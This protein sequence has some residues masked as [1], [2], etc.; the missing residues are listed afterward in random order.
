[1]QPSS[2]TFEVADGIATLTLNEAERM[3]P[4]D[5]PLIQGCLDAAQRVHEDRSVR[6]LL[7]NARGRAFSVGADLS[8]LKS[9][10][11]RPGGESLGHYVGRLMAERGNPL[12]AALRALPVPVVCAV[13]GAAAGGGVGL[14]LAADIVVAARSAYFYL[15]FVPALGLVPD[16]GSSW[17]LP[18]A[19]GH[20]R[21]LGLTLL[22]DKL[23]AQ[24]AADWGLIWACVDD[25][26]LQDE[27]RLVARRL[28]ALPAHA[29]V[30]TRALFEASRK[31]D[32]EQQLAL[33][34]ERQQALIDGGAFAEGV[35][36]FGERRSPVFPGRG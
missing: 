19:V 7:L 31:N 16:M 36:A 11:Q 18:R 17:F 34:R 26:K 28:A 4:L 10:A 14:A 35:R 20:A 23:P 29:I 21:A 5:A 2:V 22:G 9:N 6:A 24:Q 27:G 30:E 12:M 13:Q 15:P 1:M 32:F 25:D 33:E 3:N 8:D